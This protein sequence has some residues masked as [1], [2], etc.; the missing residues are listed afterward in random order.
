MA[1]N[2]LL[3]GCLLKTMVQRMNEDWLSDAEVEPLVWTPQ[4]LDKPSAWWGHVPFA[5]WLVATCR[6]RLLVELGTHHGVSYVAFCEAVSRLRLAT[7]CYAVDTRS[8]DP[9]AGRYAREVYAEFKVFHDKRYSD[10]SQ[11][12]RREFDEARDSFIDGSIDVLHIDGLDTY[13]SVRDDFNSWRPKLSERAVVLFHGSNEREGSFDVSQL[14]E[15]LRRET[16]SFAFLQSHG[17]GVLAIGGNPPSQSK[18]FALCRTLK[19]R[20]CEKGFHTAA[21]DGLRK[22]KGWTSR[23]MS[24]RSNKTSAKR[25]PGPALS[26]KL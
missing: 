26:T 17:L 18:G 16:P 9:H 19:S 8:G 1:R 12:A 4:R 22:M 6:P 7:R 13:D 2:S 23:E 25:I 5:F 20:E 14:F 11:F 10:F 21:L 24:R 15:K 3:A